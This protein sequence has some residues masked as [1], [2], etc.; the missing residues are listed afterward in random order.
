MLLNKI[1]GY[2]WTSI[3]TRYYEKY[4]ALPLDPNAAFIESRGGEDLAGNMYAV[5][6]ELCQR[7]LTVYLSVKQS[8]AS[9]VNQ[10]ISQG[11][12]PG[13]RVVEKDSDEC[14]RASATATYFFNDMVYSDLMIK[15]E[16][17]VFVNTWHGTPLKTLEFDVLNQRHDMGGAT[18]GYLQCN[19]LAVP[20][21]FLAERL[22][23]S[24]QADQLYR[25]SVVY[26]GYPRNAVFFDKA[27]RAMIRQ[28]LGISD[29][30][31]FT[32]MPTWRGTFHNHTATSGAYS[33]QAILDFFEAN[34]K[35]NQV[36]Y[37]K[38]HNLAADAI[39]FDGYERVRPFPTDIDTYS[40]L[41]ATDCL[42]TDYSSVFFDYVNCGGKVV[43][44]TF[45]R[46]E[47]CA[48]RGFYLD[49][50]ELPFPKANTYE[51]LLA[52]LNIQKSYDDTE[53]RSRYC[54][55][56]A[57][58]ATGLLL[59][60]VLD[61]KTVC[62]VDKWQGNGKKNVLVYDAS[63]HQRDIKPEIAIQML[64]ALDISGANY[65]YGI[66]QSCLKATPKYLMRLPENV[67]IYPFTHHPELTTREKLGRA[68]HGETE[69]MMSFSQ[70]VLQRQMYG[71]PFDEI[72]IFENNE[73]DPFVPILKAAPNYKGIWDA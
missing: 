25:G 23:E 56:D 67:R 47:Y 66:R 57:P 18:R 32:Y 2:R 26:C 3:L 63:Y 50:D 64:D 30:E 35:P 65:H 58:N 55:Y 7:S 49:L 61:N 1:R 68:S 60:T 19:Y 70:R 28:K 72:Y 24:S 31:S 11:S 52:E 73:F 41:A 17:Q 46:D 14:F 51:E 38:L 29:R 20:C 54:T 33:T 36:I 62:R 6:K 22:L 71:N 40:M 39:N 45:D 42:I 15:R 13:L 44:F 69:G 5:A 34:L 27:S 16:G 9:K 37:V 59:D 43:L 53:F 12:F 48:D 21:E 8:H 4:C 10:I